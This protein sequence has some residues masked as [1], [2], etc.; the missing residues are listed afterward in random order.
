MAQSNLYR[1]NLTVIK[2]YKIL[3]LFSSQS[4]EVVKPKSLNISILS[5]NINIISKLEVQDIP[6]D[7]QLKLLDLF[8]SGQNVYFTGKAGTGKTVALKHFI[9]HLKEEKIPYAVTVALI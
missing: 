4:T 7:E 3:R 9:N 8:K 6:S 5:E 1:R 2:S